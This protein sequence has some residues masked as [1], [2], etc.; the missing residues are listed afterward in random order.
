MRS[1]FSLRTTAVG[2]VVVQAALAA[3]LTAREALGFAVLAGFDVH[4]EITEDA[5]EQIGFFG[6]GFTPRAIEQ[7]VDGNVHADKHQEID[8][9]HVDNE[10]IEA[11]HANLLLIRQ[12]I[13]LL[14]ESDRFPD[15]EAA[16]KELGLALH[17]VQD[18]YAHSNWIERG[19]RDVALIGTTSLD[20]RL[21]QTAI[22]PCDAQGNNVTS[23]FT[24]G[25]YPQVTP[26]AV[27]GGYKCVHGVLVEDPA[28]IVISAMFAMSKDFELSSPLA[29]RLV[30]LVPGFDPDG[31]NERVRAAKSV[32]RQATVSFVELVISDIASNPIAVCRLLGHDP[33]QC[34]GAS[35]IVEVFATD[36][37]SDELWSF[38]RRAKTRR[39]KEDGTSTT[40]EQ[41][42]TVLSRVTSHLP[43]GRL[44]RVVATQTWVPKQAEFQG[45]RETVVGGADTGCIFATKSTTK[46][47]FN[48][49]GQYTVSTIAEETVA[50]PAACAA[51]GLHAHSGEI[52]FETGAVVRANPGSTEGTLSS[53]FW[54][55]NREIYRSTQ[56]ELGETVRYRQSY[57][58]DARQDVD[59]TA[60]RLVDTRIVAPNEPYPAECHEF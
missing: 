23:L 42:M 57:S 20:S 17:T 31:Y 1:L 53:V 54:R 34:L 41:N 28:D 5:L 3:L 58:T 14:V 38:Q 46:H 48:E 47:L 21:S 45:T 36:S 2:C 22:A 19:F 60:L 50:T 43:S 24:S 33:R 27:V 32:A 10:S 30:A 18:F 8:Y 37:A 9:Y 12:K 26:F 44:C 11:A 51:L 39:I 40:N 55:I 16:R 4:Q 6:L 15:W 25:Y 29:A 56:T 13:K 59:V 49:N 52:D 35:Q 7:I